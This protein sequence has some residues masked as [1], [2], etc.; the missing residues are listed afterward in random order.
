VVLHQPLIERVDGTH[1]RVVTRP[2][3]G[4]APDAGIA[5]LPTVSLTR[6][7]RLE[8]THISLWSVVRSA[9]VFWAAAAGALF[10]FLVLAWGFASALGL[11]D[12]MEELAADML[13]AD[14]VSIRGAH[15]LGAAGLLAVLLAGLATI[16][17]TIAAAVY[18][19]GAHLIGG[20]ELDLDER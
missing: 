17:T 18:N 15:V 5:L 13:G 16:V 20:V 8:V 11:L 9:A 3:D 4:T 7:E 19:L 6:G 14:Q 2:A 1:R 12:S 10:L